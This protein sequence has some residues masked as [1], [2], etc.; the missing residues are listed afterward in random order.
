VAL[1]R[2][3]VATVADEVTNQHVPARGDIDDA[4]RGFA[5]RTAVEE[6]ARAG[7]AV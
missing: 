1:P 3:T 5:G 6:Y 2:L 7:K 4:Q